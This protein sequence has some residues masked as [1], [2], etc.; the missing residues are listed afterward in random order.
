[1][2]GDDDNGVAPTTP[3]QQEREDKNEK[4]GIRKGQVPRWIAHYR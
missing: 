4:E 1:M 3:C 2:R